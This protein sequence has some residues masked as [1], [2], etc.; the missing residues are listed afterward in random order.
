MTAPGPDSWFGS[1][2][3]G[4]DGTADPVNRHRPDVIW[5]DPTS[6]VPSRSSIEPAG[7]IVL[8]PV[9]FG[10]TRSQVEDLIDLDAPPPPPAQR[11]AP[12]RPTPATAV[13]ASPGPP[14]RLPAV[15]QPLP[16]PTAP[17]QQSAWASGSLPAPLNNFLSGLQQTSR[18]TRSAR[19]P[20]R[21][22]PRRTGQG[23]SVFIFVVVIGFI[24][25]VSGAGEQLVHLISDLFRE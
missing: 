16:P 14:P 23:A 15:R 17:P 18:P 2:L 25:L 3:S 4:A 22:S 24:L 7:T 10:M 11:Q 6:A 12:P 5:S 1:A 13:R 20:S 21:Q 8:P 9:H 19:P